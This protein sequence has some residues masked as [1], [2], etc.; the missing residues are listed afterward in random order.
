MN[1]TLLFSTDAREWANEFV[2]IFGGDVD[3]MTTWFA[4]A[5]E[6]GRGA[7]ILQGSAMIRDQVQA[8]VDR[9]NQHII[10]QPDFYAAPFIDADSV[11]EVIAD[12]T[13]VTPTEDSND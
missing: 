9:L 11:F 12:T 3:L 10:F 5:I 2:R 6:T 4:S 1:E 13:G 7:G 8:A